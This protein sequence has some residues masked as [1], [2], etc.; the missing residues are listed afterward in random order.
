MK[1]IFILVLLGVAPLMVSA[2]SEKCINSN[3]LAYYTPETMAS[4]DKIIF[5]IPAFVPISTFEASL[6]GKSQAVQYKNFG[7]IT[8]AKVIIPERLSGTIRASLG[9]QSRAASCNAPV[10]FSFRR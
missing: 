6:N 10:D 5:Y 9:A 1:K 7:F 4:Q 3:I 8:R 2:D